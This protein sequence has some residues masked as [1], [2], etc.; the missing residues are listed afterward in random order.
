MAQKKVVGDLVYNVKGDATGFGTVI[1]KAEN[2]IKRL[3]RT[4]D[5]TKNSF[6]NIGKSIFSVKNAIGGFIAGFAGRGL[7]NIAKAGAQYDSLTQSFTRLSSSMEINGEEA[8]S[9][10]RKFSA[11]TISN[12]DLIQSANRA[13]VLGVAKSTEEFGTLMQ[14]ARIR[15]ADMG[16]STTQA[17]NDIVTGIGRS[18][19]L[20]LDNL[21]IVIKQN[22]AYERYAESLNKTSAALTDNEKRE[23]LKFAVLEDAKKQIKEVG[24]V[25]V[26]YSE[27]LQ[28]AETFVQNLRDG[29]G[30][31]LLPAFASLLD[32]TG[33]QNTSFLQTTEQVN[34]LG[35]EFYRAGQVVIGLGRVFKVFFKSVKVGMSVLVAGVAG[36]Y[37]SILGATKSLKEALGADTSGIE[38][39]IADVDLFLGALAENT[40]ESVNGMVDDSEK[41]FEAFSEA[42]DPKNYKG[43][44]DGQMAAMISGGSGSVAAAASEAGKEAEEAAKKFEDFQK[45]MIGVVD[46]SREAQKA[47]GEE[48]TGA[49]KEFGDNLTANAEETAEGLAS[50]F[51]SAEKQIADLKKESRGTDDSDRRKEIRKEIKAQEEILNE[52]KKFEERDAERV[53]AIRERLEAAGINAAEAGVDN[54][55]T[56]RDL[57]AEIQEQRRLADLN[58]FEL[59]EAEQVKKREA[60]VTALIDE[61]TIINEKIEKQK[62]LEMEVTAFVLSQNELREDSVRSFADSAI[63]KYGEMASSLRSA[64][65]LQQRLNSLRS[66]PRQF[67]DGGHVDA[68][69]GEVHAGEYVIPAKMA[70][71]YR[72]LISN[73]ESERRGGTSVNNSR[74]VNAPININANVRDEVDFRAISS[75]LAWELQSK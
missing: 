15:A 24:E 62:A 8:L 56:V 65:S 33:S 40:K 49:F 66:N 54:L 13:M 44:S 12:S 39:S 10:L 60:L 1:T 57:E 6:S 9:T 52:R 29:I 69:G 19:P 70:S 32:A 20:I 25:T 4:M 51:L 17:F 46:S 64:I 74:T 72:G 43:L 30:R 61:V 71:K 35:K 31:A 3:K 14:V 27:R 59:F 16:L 68:R 2:Q 18:S 48:L 50:I 47:L 67:H 53:A 63:A 5:S 55:L 11:G 73:L 28:Q 26:S 41:V 34:D 7:Y 21:G 42:Y 22:E 36:G 45:Q 58:A 38:K 37:K 75:A 23:A